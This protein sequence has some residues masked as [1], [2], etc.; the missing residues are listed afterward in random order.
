MDRPSRTAD[1][2]AARIR[3]CSKKTRHDTQPQEMS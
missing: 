1:E 2:L 3:P